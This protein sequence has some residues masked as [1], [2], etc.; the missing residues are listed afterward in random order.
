M[1][2]MLEHQILVLENVRYD[3][4]LFEKELKKSTQWLD[5]TELLQLKHWILNNYPYMYSQTVHEMFEEVNAV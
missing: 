5:S 2:N 1:N 3:D 4:Y